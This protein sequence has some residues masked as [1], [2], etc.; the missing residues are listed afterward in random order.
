MQKY[1][2][3][4][5]EETSVGYFFWKT[6]KQNDGKVTNGIRF[7]ECLKFNGYLTFLKIVRTV[8]FACKS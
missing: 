4:Y 1:K 8:Y 5:I 7:D 2:G 3:K 6:S